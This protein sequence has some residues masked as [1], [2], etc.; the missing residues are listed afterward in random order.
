MQPSNIAH[1][2]HEVPDDEQACISTE[3]LQFESFK[4]VSTP[5]RGK[6]SISM[7]LLSLAGKITL[8]FSQQ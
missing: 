8:T 2:E 7:H 1:E 6:T 5:D 3:D 4:V